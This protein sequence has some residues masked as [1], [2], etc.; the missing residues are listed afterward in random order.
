MRRVA[1]VPAWS[2]M[3]VRW[4]RALLAAGALGALTACSGGGANDSASPS[5]T[6]A[7]TTTAAPTTSAPATTSPV[8][9][10]AAGTLPQPVTSAAAPAAGPAQPGTTLVTL[11]GG[12]P[13][14]FCPNLELSFP[15]SFVISVGGADSPTGAAIAEVAMAPVLADALDAL[16]RSAPREL[17]GPFI[18]WDDRNRQAMA[19]FDK[20][21]VP[22]DKVAAYVNELRSELTKMQSGQ[23]DGSVLEDLPA[24][25]A[26][27][28]I[29]RTKLI[30]EGT[31]FGKSYGDFDDFFDQF[32]TDITLS[33]D[34]QDKLAQQFPCTADLA[35]PD[36]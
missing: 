8:T 16:A 26:K 15:A 22:P 6:S 11:T 4:T 9:A 21:G 31:Q 18:V 1:A 30:A 28:G 20:L 12:D 10:P 34:V 3:P 36:G 14:Q 5:S 33:P 23:S 25:A 7:S 2:A 19:A 35:N 17:A 24:L 29:D 27:Y 32:S 13:A